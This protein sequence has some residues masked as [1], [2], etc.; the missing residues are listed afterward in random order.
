MLLCLDCRCCRKGSHQRLA[1]WVVP[2]GQYVGW[3]Q[4]SRKCRCRGEVLHFIT[5]PPYFS[6]YFLPLFCRWFWRRGVLSAALLLSGSTCSEM[7]GSKRGWSL[8]RC[9]CKQTSYIPPPIFSFPL[10]SLRYFAYMSAIV[11]QLTDDLASRF[12]TLCYIL[13]SIYTDVSVDECFF[14]FF[15]AGKRRALRCF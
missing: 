15:C 2:L 3:C 7:F 5:T 8:M 6:S 1:V 4:V 13:C 9:H 11:I 10:F 12:F 14:C